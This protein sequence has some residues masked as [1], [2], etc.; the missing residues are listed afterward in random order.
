VI[1]SPSNVGFS[2][3]L[4]WSTESQVTSHVVFRP[5]NESNQ[6][7]IRDRSSKVEISHTPT[8][9]HDRQCDIRGSGRGGDAL[10]GQLH[11]AP[12]IPAPKTSGSHMSGTSATT[13]L[14]MCL[15][16]SG[17]GRGQGGTRIKV[18]RD[19]DMLAG[20]R[21]KPYQRATPITTSTSHA[22]HNQA[23]I[24]T[25]HAYQRGRRMRLGT[26]NRMR[27]HVSRLWR[28]MVWRSALVLPANAGHIKMLLLAKTA[29]TSSASPTSL[30]PRS[31][32]Y[33]G[34]IKALLRLKALLR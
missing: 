18:P 26:C 23:P 25:R 29:C 15:E 11:A 1:G 31:R 13:G 22:Y 9:M 32:R 7:A 21:R 10:V 12:E 20:A 2:A 16:E 34:A 17:S 4:C 28:A 27:K 8:C 14:P 3:S 6:K 5:F 33:Q 24:S 30:K 19:R